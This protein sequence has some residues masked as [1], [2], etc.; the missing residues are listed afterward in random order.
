M[1]ASKKR[2]YV[3]YETCDSVIPKG[4]F[5]ECKEKASK[6]KG[7]VDSSTLEGG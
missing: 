4:G 2:K 6:A 1:G 5:V 7:C 3:G